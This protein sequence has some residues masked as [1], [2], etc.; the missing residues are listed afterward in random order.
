MKEYQ[1]KQI[2]V[3]Q[4]L[5]P[6]VFELPLNE[7]ILLEEQLDKLKEFGIVIEHFGKNEFILREIPIIINK[8]ANDDLIKQLIDDILKEIS[9]QNSF[10]NAKEDIIKQISCKSSYHAGD[11]LNEVLVK[12]LLKDLSNTENPFTCPHGRPSIVKFNLDE[13]W[14]LFRRD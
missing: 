10:D 14:K 5:S 13:L 11:D 12:K 2:K 6:K 9:T 3:Q 8:L 1:N 7:S 4:L